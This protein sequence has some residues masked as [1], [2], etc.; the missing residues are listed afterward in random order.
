VTRPRPSHVLLLLAGVLVSVAILAIVLPKLAHLAPP[1]P[2]T[3]T[4]T[5][6]GHHGLLTFGHLL[7]V[8]ALSSLVSGA[9]VIRWGAR[10]VR[11]RIENRVSRTYGLYEI[12]L[13]LH[14]EARPQDV[15][16]M[17]EGLLNTV[18]EFPEHRA[19]QGQPFVAFE[20][21]FGPGATGELE[22]VLCLRC[23]PTI[24][25]ALDGIISGA[26]PDVRVGYDFTGPPSEIAGT[27]AIPGHVLRFRK[28]RSFVFPLDVEVKDG[29]TRLLEAVAQAQAALQKPSTVRI[30]LVPCALPIERYA[31]ERL[32]GHEDRLAVGITGGAGA[33]ERAEMTAAA[34]SQ[35]H[36][37]CWLE[38]Q[39]AAGS[40]AHANRIAA[41]LQSRRGQNRLHRRWMLAREDLYRRRFPTA[42][43]PLLP[44]ASLRGLASASEVAQ[45]LALPGARLRNVPVRRGALPRMPAPPEVPM[46]SGDAQPELPPGVDGLEGEP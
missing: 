13:S 34:R 5:R 42:Y 35:E 28:A 10:L 37:W 38:V 23:E 30:Q 7:L 39:V 27:I 40:R 31:R 21:H 9:L 20:A 44:S 25:Q 26:Y 29:A 14:D 15:I 17:V 11:D 3:A 36:S 16:D 19:R 32:R 1:T 46:A 45:L 6:R 33:L 22:W 24:V 18:R 8:F 2:H 41:A 43:P 4:H 12:R